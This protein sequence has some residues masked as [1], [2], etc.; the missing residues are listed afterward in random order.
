MAT[1]GTINYKGFQFDY[2]Y[3][4]SAGSPAT[5]EDPEEYDE[6]EIYNITLNG[7]DAEDLIEDMREDFEQEVIDHLTGN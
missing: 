5:W 4:F 3:N 1:L 7:I 6:W 2:E